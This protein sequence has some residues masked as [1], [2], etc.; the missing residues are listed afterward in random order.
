MLIDVGAGGVGADVTLAAMGRH[1]LTA[2]EAAAAAAKV[3]AIQHGKLARL[4][5]GGAAF[6]TALG[7][8]S[9]GF[10]I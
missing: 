10:P 8:H 9:W 6:C 7:G 2:A 1:G 3:Q 5:E 4:D